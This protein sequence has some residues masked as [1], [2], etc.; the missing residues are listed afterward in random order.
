MCCYLTSGKF[1]LCLFFSILFE[2][3]IF[4]ANFSI[5]FEFF[6]FFEIF[7]NVFEKI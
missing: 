4:S 2:K 5:L 3:I 7:S 6:Y 1:A